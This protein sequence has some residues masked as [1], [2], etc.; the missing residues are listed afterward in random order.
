M[1]AQCSSCLG[2]V[3]VWV[4]A[5][6]IIDLIICACFD[7]FVYFVSSD[8]ATLI[9]HISV[10]VCGSMDFLKQFPYFCVK[11]EDFLKKL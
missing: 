8:K 9:D 1:S 4:V 2:L 6:S 3:W 10:P 11:K 7:R 5:G